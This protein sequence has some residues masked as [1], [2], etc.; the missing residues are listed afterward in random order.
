MLLYETITTV[1]IDKQKN[2]KNILKLLF[3]NKLK[4]KKQIHVTC[5]L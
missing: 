3:I 4:T 1:K 5:M 2:F